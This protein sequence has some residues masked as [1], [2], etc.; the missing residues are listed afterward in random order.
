MR[1]RST[2]RR[3]TIPAVRRRALRWL[4]APA[5]ALSP[6]A[7]VATVALA[8]LAAL[9]LAPALA[10]SG[11]EGGGGGGNPGAVGVTPLTVDYS[12]VGTIRYVDNAGFSGRS[13]FTTRVGP[14]ATF[15]MD[16][17]TLK[18]AASAELPFVSYSSGNS[19]N[20]RPFEPNLRF[21]GRYL[22]ERSSFGLNANFRRGRNFDVLDEDEFGGFRVTNAQL[23]TFSISPNYGHA[24]TERLSLNV[25]YGYS[26]R[27][28]SQ[29]GPGLIDTD[30]HS[31]GGGLSYRLTELDTV[32]TSLSHSRFRT[33]PN[34]TSNDSTSVQVSWSRQWTELTSTSVYAGITS[35]DIEGQSTQQV[36][37]VPIFFC[38]TGL[39]PFETVQFGTSSNNRTPTYGFTVSTR[40]T[41]TTSLSMLLNR[42]V[43][44]GS[45]GVLTDRESLGASL[46]HQFS[47]RLSGNLG[48][49]NTSTQLVGTVGQSVSNRVQSLSSGLSYRLPDNWALSGGA[50]ISQTSLN[51]DSRQQRSVFVTVSK[52]WPNNRL[53]PR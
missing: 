44:A 1:L 53:W 3:R 12:L 24:I 15:R 14:R 37:L 42:G 21:T 49:T 23:T 25:N 35:S 7:K 48:Y 38:E 10:Q 6:V 17:E 2:L 5:S 8:A 13:T 52:G 28:H 46:G 20:S 11:A 16:S 27:F 22:Q 9:P 43:Q 36:C 4:T 18:L 29:S 26:N 40:L 50:Q 39:V 30:S 47:E 45:T 34:T 32:S 31:V 33:D 19:D 51:V 41:E